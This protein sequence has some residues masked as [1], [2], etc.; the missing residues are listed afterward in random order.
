MTTNDS[1]LSGLTVSAAVLA[2]LLGVTGKAIYELAKSGI[3]ERASKG[4]YVLESSVRG[5]CEHTRRAV[6]TAPSRVAKRLPHLT[7]HDI[8]AIDAEVQAIF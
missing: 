4:N 3:I 2:R 1:D 8:S 5:Y 7:P 6:L